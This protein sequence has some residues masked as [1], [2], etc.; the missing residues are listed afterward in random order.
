LASGARM[1]VLD[2]NESAVGVFSSTQPDD[3]ATLEGGKF[4][5]IISSTLGNSFSFADGASGVKIFTASLNPT[6]SD[7]YAKVLNTDPDRFV[8][9]QHLLYADFAVDDEVA[10]ATHVG[11][12][13]GSLFTSKNSGETSTE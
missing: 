5:L 10:S 2:G 1:C 8:T 6:A 3:A 12:M 9:E 11:M 13:S 7:Y 4:K